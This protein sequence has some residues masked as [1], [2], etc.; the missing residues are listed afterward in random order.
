LG[1]DPSQATYP[2]PPK[3]LLDGEHKEQ[4]QWSVQ[5]QQ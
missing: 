3:N 2:L 1:F 4:L 5:Q